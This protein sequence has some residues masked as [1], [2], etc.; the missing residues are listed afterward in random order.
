MLNGKRDKPN[1]RECKRIIDDLWQLVSEHGSEKELLPLRNF[2][3]ITLSIENQ[4]IRRKQKKNQ[5]N[6]ILNIC[7]IYTHIPLT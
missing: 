3:S 7:S 6:E 2:C 1:C 4:M 5:Y